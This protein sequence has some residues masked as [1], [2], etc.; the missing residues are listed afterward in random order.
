MGT[1]QSSRGPKG[2][3]PIVPE[4]IARGPLKPGDP[5]RFT[6]FRTAFGNFL[7]SGNEGDLR[8]ALSHYASTASGGAAQ[9]VNRLTPAIGA[10][11][12]LYS[13]LSTGST[14]GAGINLTDLNG[15]PC[16]E[17]IQTI[18]EALCQGSKDADKI[19]VALNDALAVALEGIEEFS[20]NAITQEVL[21]ATMEYY[22]SEI[23]FLQI[24]NDSGEAW[25]RATSNQKTVDAE[26]E[27]FELI[28]VV[29]EQ[30]FETALTDGISTESIEKI[31]KQT[32]RDVWAA[33]RQY[34]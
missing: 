3:S 16:E 5:K 32:V 1:S 24:V 18:A 31:Q 7:G 26:I 17:A 9:A 4:S 20:D 19:R 2:T 21:N 13:L 8:K 14:S 15:R 30:S 29:V 12:A 33:W 11:T 10:G 27:L 6:Q 23:I 25:Y 28:K 34:S 22:L